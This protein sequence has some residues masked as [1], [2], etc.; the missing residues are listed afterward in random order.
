MPLHSRLDET[1]LLAASPL[2]LVLRFVCRYLKH[3]LGGVP[4]AWLFISHVLAA[5]RAY[6]VPVDV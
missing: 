1:C 5:S 3:N 2:V 6:P 4:I